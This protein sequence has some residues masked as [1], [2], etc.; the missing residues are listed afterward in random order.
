MLQI[1]VALQILFIISI[2]AFIIG[3][4]WLAI[5]YIRKKAFKIPAAMSIV[6]LV[7]VIVSVGCSIAV[8]RAIDTELLRMNRS[9]KVKSTKN[10]NGDEPSA[11]TTGKNS[12]KLDRDGRRVNIKDA[13]TYST[14]YSDSSWNDTTVKIDKVT[15]YKTKHEYSNDDG[16]FNG[17]V[18]VH[19]D[20]HVDHDI[21][22]YA[23]QATLNTDDGQQVDADMRASGNFDG[24]LNSGAHSDGNVYFLLPKLDAVSSLHTL[25]LKFDASY[26]TED[27]D[28]DNSMHTYDVTINLH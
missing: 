13:K 25:R 27:F 3:L 14:T 17:I 11:T 7:V 21:S 8:D 15:V 16:T 22:M 4:V 18:K 5:N 28:D 10:I 20:I 2:V 9:L 24:D 19:F 6:A 26:E 12:I 1:S 23:T